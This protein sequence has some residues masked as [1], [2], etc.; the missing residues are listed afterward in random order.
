MICFPSG[1]RRRSTCLRNR[2]GL[3]CV[4]Y[5][6]LHMVTTIPCIALHSSATIPC[7][8]HGKHHTLYRIAHQHMVATI[9]CSVLHVGITLPCI[10]NQYC[11]TLYSTCLRTYLSVHISTTKMATI[12]TIP[13][14]W[15]GTCTMYCL[16][17]S[18]QVPTVPCPMLCMAFNVLA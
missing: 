13:C 1:P 18:A 17:H 15:H 2:C 6:V 8:A 10:A 3:R 16:A 4:P 7:I 11:R 9:P 12:P 5:R 14:I